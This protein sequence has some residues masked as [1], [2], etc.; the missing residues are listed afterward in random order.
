MPRVFEYT[1]K[2]SELPLSLA[3]FLKKH[4]YSR[5]M[6]VSMKH[7][8]GVLVNGGFY[9]MIDPLTKNDRIRVSLAEETPSLPANTR[10]DVPVLYED[11]D[12]LAL[13]KP[14]DM[15]VHPAGKGFNDA[16]GNFFTAHCPGLIFRPLGRLDRHTT[17]ICLIAKNRLAAAK[18]TGKIDKTYYAI[19]QG[20]MEVASGTI[21]APLLRVGGP[22]ITNQVNESGKASRTRFWLLT[23][24]EDYSY[25]RLKLDTGRMHQIRVHMQHIGHPLAGDAL[26]GGNC[27][28]ISRQSLHCGKIVFTHPICGHRIS[29]EAPLPEDMRRLLEII[30]RQRPPAKKD[31]GLTD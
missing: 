2:A 13:D 5:S 18:L 6:I 25:L 15:L 30:T 17:G 11:D 27:N 22:V 28:E 16:A 23:R 10:L 7:H 21:D 12:I 14:D 8:G 24:N 26:Y 19:A 3:A 1:V 20:R 9:R 4:G 29:L 31:A